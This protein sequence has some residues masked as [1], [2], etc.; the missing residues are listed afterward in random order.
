MRYKDIRVGGFYERDENS[1]VRE[2]VEIDDGPKPINARAETVLDR[3]TFREPFLK[4]RCLIPAD[5]FYEWKKMGGRKQPYHIRRPD[6]NPLAFAGLWD[7]WEGPE[8]SLLTCCILTTAANELVKTLHDRMPCVVGP[9]EFARWLDPSSTPDQRAALMRPC[10]ADILE[11]V[12][13]GT[14][15][16]SP[17]NDGPECLAPVA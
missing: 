11:A 15:V 8:G 12:P 13:V 7:R 10:P 16:N 17:K 9:D 14:G 6:G 1:F 4:R 5:G 2:V 3:P